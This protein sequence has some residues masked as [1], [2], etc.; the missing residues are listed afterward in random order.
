MKGTPFVWC[1]IAEFSTRAGHAFYFVGALFEF[2]QGFVAP[3][4]LALDPHRCLVCFVALRDGPTRCL[5][6][7]AC[8]ISDTRIIIRLYT[9]L[10][11]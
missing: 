2:A 1:F 3:A 9:V 4:Q 11:F 5:S 10:F 6:D 8:S 7:K